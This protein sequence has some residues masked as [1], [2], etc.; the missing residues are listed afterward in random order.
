MSEGLESKPMLIP[1]Q[2]TYLI[3]QAQQDPIKFWDDVARQE[4]NLIYWKRL[5]DKTFEWNGKEPYKWFIGGI[6][7]AEY[8]HVDYQVEKGYGNKAIYIYENAELG[9]TRA[10][11]FYQYLDMVKSYAAAMRAL[12][13]RKGDRVLLY[14][15]TRVEAIAVLHAAARIGA[16]ASSVYAGFSAGSLRDRILLTGAKVVFTQDYNMRRGKLIELK[17]IVD[18]ALRGLN[19]SPVKNVVVF[20]SEYTEKEAPMASPRDISFGEFLSKSK[21]GSGDVEWVESN[22]PLLITPTSGTTAKPKPV[23]HKHGPFQVHV[24][25][26]GKWVYAL[27]PDD[28]WFITSDVGWQAGVSYMVWGVPIFGATS[29]VYDGTP[30]YPRPDMWWEVIERDRVTKLWISPTGIRLLSK[31]GVSY[32]KKHD[33]SSLKV[34]FSAG[35]PLNPEPL[36]WLMHDVLDDRVPVIDHYWQTET[37]GPVVG[38]PYGIQM[39]PI[40]PG[41]AGI[42]LPGILGFVANEETGRPAKP[43]EKGVFVIRQPFPGYTSELWQDYEWYLSSYWNARP[44]L[45][46]M[47]YSGDAAMVDE[48]GY[49]WFLGRADD[50]IKISAHRIGT[51]ELESALVSHPAVAEAAVIGV[52][53]PTRG[54]VAVGFVVLKEGYK[55]SEELK[56]EL[57][58]HVRKVYGPIAVFKTIE[59]V[60][61]LPK[62]RSGKI[63]RRVIRAVYLNEPLGD[64]ST[65]EDEAEVDEIRKAV[66]QFRAA[67]KEEA[68][69]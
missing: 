60:K 49:I 36:R 30:D 9:I 68:R 26:M 27:G 43:G 62:T 31:Y 40:K 18:E 45:K 48:D 53:D 11:T 66:E 1:P 6:T 10:Y 56:R 16:I 33:L 39:I 51:F 47:I 42:T 34:V 28:T 50:V 7:N 22:E 12:G 32:A 44:Q 55:P 69:G 20:K 38:N 3:K 14:M 8:S 35:E 52:P 19:G 54:Q 5:W 63:M 23:V 57:I 21:E 59:I 4:T 65:L 67:M 2:V 64:L 46:G 24:V 41:S 37:G 61:A 58:E 25:T 29:V 15:P 17:S 13:V